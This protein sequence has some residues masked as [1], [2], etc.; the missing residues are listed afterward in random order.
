MRHSY[1]LHLLLTLLLPVLTLQDELKSNTTTLCKRAS[2]NGIVIGYYTDR[3]SQQLPPN[4]IDYRKITHINYAVALIDTNTY[5]SII[6][7]TSILADLVN[8]AHK[9]YVCVTVL[10][11]N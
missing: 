3:N 1:L 4:K 8:N 2:G 5:V 10:I 9:H 6:Q 7:T 11:G